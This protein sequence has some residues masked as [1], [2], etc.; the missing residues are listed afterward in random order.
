MSW[1]EEPTREVTSPCA[2]RTDNPDTLLS[3]HLV[4][5]GLLGAQQAADLMADSART[6]ISFV[7]RLVA[8]HLSAS[9]AL[10]QSL[11]A[12]SG[13]RYVPPTH[14]HPARRAVELF[15]AEQ[16]KEVRGLPIMIDESHVMMAFAL[17]PTAEQLG[18]ARAIAK[19]P[20]VAG[21]RRDGRAA[22]RHPCRLP[23]AGA[24]GAARGQLGP[25]NGDGAAAAPLAEPASDRDRAR[26]TS[27]NCSSSCSSCADRTCT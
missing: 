13:L 14:L 5:N 10:A 7:N 9:T 15:T 6:G 27:T 12:V 17:P 4:N 1:P 22:R 25:P 3:N 24:D 21:H 11:A 20:V 23:P 26:R 16:A 19:R 8:G 2:P 18:Q